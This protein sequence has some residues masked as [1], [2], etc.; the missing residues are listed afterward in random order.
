MRQTPWLLSLALHQDY[1][2]FLA[3]LAWAGV[4][5]AW[6]KFAR[7]DAA[8][9]WLP[10]SAAAGLAVCGLELSLIITPVPLV[11]YVAQRHGWDLALG[12][13][14]ALQLAGWGW[15]ALRHW[16]RWPR[17]LAAGLITLLAAGAAAV[18]GGSASAAQTGSIALAAAT[19]AAGLLFVPQ[20][21]SRPIALAALGGAAIA[22]WLSSFGPLA[23]WVGAPRAFTDL[24]VLGPWAAAAQ[25]V[26]AGLAG[27]GLARVVWREVGLVADEMRTDARSMSLWLGGWLGCGLVFAW[28]MGALARGQFTANALGRVR[29]SAALIDSVALERVLNGRFT[30]GPMLSAPMLSGREGAVFRANN[31]SSADLAPI[32]RALSVI[33][34]ANPDINWARIMTI[35]GGYVVEVCESS[36]MPPGAIPGTVAVQNVVQEED[37]R[38][39]AERRATLIGPIAVHYGE[40]VHV[41]APLVTANNRM[42]GWLAFDYELAPWMAAQAQ[43]RLLAFVVVGLGSTLTVMFWL[44]RLH[45]RRQ[46]LARRA[47]AV[48]AEADRAKTAFLAK[49]SHELRTPIQSILGYGELLADVTLDPQPRHWLGAVRAQ[50]QLL[51]RLV[52][53]L[54]DLSALQAGAFRIAERPGDLGALVRAVTD[55]LQPRASA[56]GIALACEVDAAVPPWLAFDSERLRQVLLNLVNNALKY[57]AQGEVRVM[58]RVA[59]A[60]VGPNTPALLELEVR[61]TGPGIAPEDQGRLFQPFS[62]LENEPGIEGAGL[63]LALTA[64][65]CASMGGSVRVESDGVH[66]SAFTARLPFRLTPPAEIQS[67]PTTVSLAGHRVLVADDNPLVRELFVSALRNAGAWCETAG[68]GLE[69]VERC[70]RE[71]FDTVVIDIS[72]PWLDGFETARRL[73]TLGAASLRIVGV[74]AHATASDRERAL[75]E[76]M[77]AFLVKPVS[78]AALVAAVGSVATSPEKASTND[79]GLNLALLR[80][81]RAHFQAEA[82]R[83]RAEI[84]DACQADDRRWLRARVHYLKNSSDVVGF[85]ELSLLCARAEAALGAVPPPPSAELRP[86]IDEILQKLTMVPPS[87]GYSEKL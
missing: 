73:R 82:A 83:L 78:I 21:R 60:S 29:A 55:S 18:R 26:T 84:H 42:L 53:D 72:M 74:S 8:W 76:G 23:R 50:G 28:A 52:N 43:A 15:V 9:R 37:W 64:A 51:I 2:W 48:A 67:P 56:K 22:L 34:L 39:W 36:R 4:L 3:A 62:R 75:A 12:A 13:T 35:R 87:N 77:D 20:L 86:L 54:I 69:A 19:T 58:L 40:I 63:G 47:A 61:D 5:W 17:G 46:E 14:A 31:L 27:W 24:S 32:E 30:L 68:D 41:R 65:I 79:P 45:Q 44:Q 70:A 80:R 57:T 1:A 25:L 49:V 33:E 16:S 81:L 71:N 59:V 85:F 66:G 7:E 6:V 38:D 10:W 11:P